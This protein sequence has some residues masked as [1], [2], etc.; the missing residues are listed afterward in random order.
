MR[1]AN[2]SVSLAENGIQAVD[3][4]RQQA[5]DLVFMDI[6]M[7][8]LDGIKATG[9]IRQSSVVWR[10]LPII[11][12][13]A[14]AIGTEREVC[15]AAGMNDYIS[16]PYTRMDLIAVVDRYCT[17]KSASEYQDE[18]PSVE[19]ADDDAAPRTDL[20]VVCESEQFD[21]DTLTELVRHMPDTTVNS[22]ITTFVDEADQRTEQIQT[23]VE[24]RCSGEMSHE[25]A[26]KKLSDQIHSL[27]GEAD[28]FGA[29]KLARTARDLETICAVDGVDSDYINI[30]NRLTVVMNELK[31]ATRELR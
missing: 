18:E 29:I 1:S 5:F 7:P 22:L 3:A 17:V 2:I 20:E 4:V 11:A 31:Q 19:F 16:K 12:L 23:I 27:K 10:D 21:L 26:N 25:S 9:A 30:A 14:D 8:E 24:S 13:T 6:R 28:T 15:I